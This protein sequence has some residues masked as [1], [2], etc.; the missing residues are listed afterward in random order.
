MCNKKNPVHGTGQ[1]K[2]SGIY[3]TQ[4]AVDVEAALIVLSG[5]NTNLTKDHGSRSCS[6]VTC[7]RNGT[8][9]AETVRGSQYCIH[10][11]GGGLV[12]VLVIERQSHLAIDNINDIGLFIQTCIKS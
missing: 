5:G 11:S 9:N 1:Q 7:E 2:G 3:S 6:L 12:C 10:S 8:R 4:M